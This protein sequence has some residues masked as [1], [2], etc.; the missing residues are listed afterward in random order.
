MMPLAV[1]QADHCYSHRPLLPAAL[2]H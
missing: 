1:P 2:P